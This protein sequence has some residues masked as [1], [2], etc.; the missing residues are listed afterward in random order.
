M[1][2]VAS[3][4]GASGPGN[5]S[6]R[7]ADTSR[8][9]KAIDFGQLGYGI[10]AILVIFGW[11][12]TRY[13]DLF[14]PLYGW[15]YWIGIV[16]SS[17]MAI[18]LLYPVRKRVRLLGR[19]GA[20]KYWFRMHMIFGVAGPVLILYHS[21][22]RFGS[23][24]SSVALT[25]TL[26]VAL[27]GLVGRYLHAKVYRDLDGHR[28]TLSGLMERA[29]ISREQKRHVSVLVPDLLERM[30]DFDS[31]VTTQ[32]EGF[33]S[34]I[35]MPL[36]LAVTTRIGQWQLSHHARRH[37]SLQA[38]KSP[39]IRARKRELQKA[40]SRFVAQHLRRVRRVAELGSYERL[41]SLWHIFHL[42]FFYMLVLTALIHVLAVHMY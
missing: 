7:L 2:V 11:I 3:D 40:I 17:L 30:R 25:C 39:V 9:T 13:Y 14:D 20:T 28:R 27:S 21:N 33:L 42:P 4:I 18:L 26:L 8:L 38:R 36:K 29:H 12:A 31:V 34:T 35:L 6:G 23:L 19:F 10:A 41:F 16:G 5:V 22:F 24:N 15:G 37:I 32:P 1:S